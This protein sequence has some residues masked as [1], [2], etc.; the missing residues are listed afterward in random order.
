M[1]NKEKM[2]EYV[3]SLNNVVTYLK[4]YDD[5]IQGNK[6]IAEKNLSYSSELTTLQTRIAD[7]KKEYQD[8]AT[9][10]INLQQQQ[11]QLQSVRNPI[12]M[13]STI[14]YKY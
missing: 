4:F 12:H 8:H 1:Q 2:K 3:R 6:E 5:I 13:Y 7:R 9:S 11:A 10:L 14:P